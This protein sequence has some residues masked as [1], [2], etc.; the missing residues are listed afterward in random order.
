[1]K[2]ITLVLQERGQVRVLAGTVVTPTIMTN[3]YELVLEK[4][5]SGAKFLDTDMM[6]NFF[7]ANIKQNL[8]EYVFLFNEHL[9]E[10]EGDKKIEDLVEAIRSL[11]EK[12]KKTN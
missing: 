12:Q 2:L 9:N 10:I 3:L 7:A 6:D 8:T 1:M 5:N 4:I 11:K